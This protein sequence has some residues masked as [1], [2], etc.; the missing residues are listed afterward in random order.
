MSEQRLPVTG[1]ARV[2]GALETGT[3]RWR[4]CS[5]WSWC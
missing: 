1:H 4:L 2:W 3:E 5:G